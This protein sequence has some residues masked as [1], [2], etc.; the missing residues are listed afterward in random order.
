MR[1]RLSSTTIR[2]LYQCTP[3]N[4]ALMNALV[5]RDVSFSSRRTLYFSIEGEL[6]ND[7]GETDYAT[8]LVPLV[9]KSTSG[10]SE[11]VTLLSQRESEV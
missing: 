6:E 8:S 11:M 1:G 10:L 2:Q 9:G 7:V 3:G 4:S 5:D